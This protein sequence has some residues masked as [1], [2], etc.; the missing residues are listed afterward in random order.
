[1]GQGTPLNPAPGTGQIRKGRTK[2]QGEKTGKKKLG[3]GRG[4][5]IIGEVKRATEKIEKD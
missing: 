4:G 3:K 1:V 5:R 2:G